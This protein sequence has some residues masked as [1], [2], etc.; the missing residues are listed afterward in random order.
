MGKSDSDKKSI[1]SKGTVDHN[2]KA[3]LSNFCLEMR[4]GK[5]RIIHVL[6]GLNSSKYMEASISYQTF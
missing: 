4:N 6:I 1:A 5:S 2:S 3:V